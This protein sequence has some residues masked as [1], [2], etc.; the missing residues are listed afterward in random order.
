[1]R[2]YFFLNKVFLSINLIFIFLI[3]L[4]NVGKAYIFGQII[5]TITANGSIKYLLIIST[6]FLLSSFF[7][8]MISD[9]LYEKLSTN[10]LISIRSELI[11]GMLNTQ[12]STFNKNLSSIYINNLSNDI[13]IIYTDYI[14]NI[15]QMLS[16][17]LSFGLALYMLF[18]IDIIYG[19]SVITISII[20]ILINR[21]FITSFQNFKKDYSDSLA[22]LISKSKNI[23]DGYP[24]IKSFNIENT[25]S[26]IFS[27]INKN[28]EQHRFKLRTKEH[29]I[30]NF[31]GC[32][33]LGIFISILLIGAYMVSI[34]KITMGQML[35]ASQ[36]SN[37][38]IN[39]LQ[40]ISILI[41]KIKS[42]DIIY[43]NLEETIAQS[44]SKNYGNVSKCTFNNEINFD[45]LT[46][47][48][49]NKVNILDNVNLTFEKN[50]IYA[51][52]GESGSGKSTC[53][54]LLQ[55]LYKD[56]KGNIYIDKINIYDLSKE[57]ISNLISTI[58]QNV[59]LFNDTIRNNICLFE[60]YDE[61]VINDVI[62]KSGLKTT[63]DKLELGLDTVIVENGSN[64]SGGEKQ[65]I[66]IARALIKNTPILVLDEATSSLDINTRTEIEKTILN[67]TN[68]TILFVTHQIDSLHTHKFDEVIL[69][70]D[71]AVFENHDIDINVNVLNSGIN[72]A[73]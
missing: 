39:P 68:K 67:I 58:D 48:Y 34:G 73:K 72:F 59:F 66:S 52:V 24:V 30:E 44:N 57:S 29:F 20:P 49:N 41:S 8:Y 51:L 54:K 60:E 71:E 53:L 32:I 38:I 45:S 1:M 4:F 15:K 37:Y 61:S 50:K 63:I 17:I 64:L 16:S 26:H 12:L 56:Y 22:M 6:I 13:N 14:C 31:N 3:S 69:F 40:T 19:I 62:N 9:I 5:D 27:S 65:R 33:A 2:K 36:L 18:K 42:I 7:V 23:L 25:I 28:T 46:F 35:M 10:I 70:G 21:L 47:S 11:N 43:S 55:G